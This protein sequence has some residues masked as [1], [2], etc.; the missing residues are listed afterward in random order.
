MEAVP[1]SPRLPIPLQ[2]G[3][4]F[5]LAEFTE[6]LK[7]AIV[8]SLATMLPKGAVTEL[9]LHGTRR[10]D[11]ASL[12]SSTG[13]WLQ[14]LETEFGWSERTA[15][16]FMQVFARKSETVSDLQIDVSA[17]YL[18]AAPKTLEPVR[19]E[20]AAKVRIRAERFHDHVS[21]GPSLTEDDGAL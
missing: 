15:Q 12:A 3:P 9:G 10:S 8:T 6:V 14:W 11:R 18:I 7:V 17:L 19:K 16:R 20:K 1:K 4:A 13:S 5:W 21:C 2:Y